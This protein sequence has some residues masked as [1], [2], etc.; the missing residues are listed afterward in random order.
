MRALFAVVALVAS[1]AAV[2]FAEEIE[3]EENVYV[4]GDSTFKKFVEDNEFVLAEFCMCCVVMAI[5]LSCCGLWL[6][7]PLC[8][9]YTRHFSI[10]GLCR[11]FGT[12]LGLCNC[13]LYAT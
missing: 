12:W 6:I 11:L 1:F 3:V 5:C 2:G 7:D 8:C 13:L 4:L 10:T 9:V